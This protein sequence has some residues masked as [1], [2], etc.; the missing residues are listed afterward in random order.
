MKILIVIGTRPE[1]IKMV[2][3]IQTL[4]KDKFF[5]V[6]ICSTGQHK[7]MLNDVFKKFKIIPHYNLNLMKK[8]QSL[9]YITEGVIHGL[10]KIIEKEEKL[11]KLS[12]EISEL[13]RTTLVQFEQTKD[14]DNSESWKYEGIIQNAQNRLQKIS[15]EIRSTY[16][17][18]ETHPANSP[19]NELLRKSEYL[20]KEIEELTGKRLSIETIADC[21]KCVEDVENVCN[22]PMVFCLDVVKMKKDLAELGKISLELKDK[23]AK[24]QKVG[25]KKKL[26]LIITSISFRS[27]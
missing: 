14:I 9:S 13:E 10:T 6:F 20:L 15:K 12:F 4:R 11:Q 19:E 18:L 8:N 27:S 5:K 25:Y 17:D 26:D 7:Q 16:P 22:K 24:L 3:V 2:S 21:E 1:A 23:E